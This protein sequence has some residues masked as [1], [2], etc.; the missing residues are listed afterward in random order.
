MKGLNVQCGARRFEGI[1]AILWDKDGTL[2]DSYGFLQKLAHQRSHSLNQKVP[3]VYDDLMAAFGCVAGQ[4]D[5]AGLMAVGTRYE[6]EIAAAA[7]VAARGH[8][9]ADSRQWV[10]S[11]FAESDRSVTRKADLTPPWRA[12]LNSCSRPSRW[13]S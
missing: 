13:D 6:N 10:Q 1:A 2:A 4:Y 9:W 5:P 3:G 12:F 8:A 7:Y 11:S